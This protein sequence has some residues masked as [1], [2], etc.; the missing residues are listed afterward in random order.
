MLFAR[1]SIRG[2][3]ERRFEILLWKNASDDFVI[4][5]LLFGFVVLVRLFRRAVTAGHQIAAETLID[6]VDAADFETTHVESVHQGR[7]RA[8]DDPNF[9]DSDDDALR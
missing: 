7:G 3:R 8:F 9:H 2:R 1:G 4:A 5:L 6:D